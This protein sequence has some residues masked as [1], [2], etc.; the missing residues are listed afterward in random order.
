MDDNVCVSNMQGRKTIMKLDNQY[1]QS[2]R[3]S[4]LE[5]IVP[6]EGGCVLLKSTI[7]LYSYIDSVTKVVCLFTEQEDE[8]KEYEWRTDLC[9]Y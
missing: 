3:N 4:L 7:I 5:R 6:L 2:N 1:Y 9:K 8:E